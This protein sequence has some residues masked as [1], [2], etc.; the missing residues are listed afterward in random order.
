MSDDR[1]T[2]PQPQQKRQPAGRRP[3]KKPVLNSTEAFERM[4]LLSC[5]ADSTQPDECDEL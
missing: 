4:A 5:G 2:T 3:Y 1:K